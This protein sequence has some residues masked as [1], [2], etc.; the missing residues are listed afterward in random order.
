M[1]SYQCCCLVFAAPHIVYLLS[2]YHRPLCSSSYPTAARPTSSSSSPT[3]SVSPQSG[4]SVEPTNEAGKEAPTR[5][6]AE[7]LR[8][9]TCAALRSRSCC[10]RGDCARGNG[11]TASTRPGDV[12]DRRVLPRPSRANAYAPARSPAALSC[13]IRTAVASAPYLVAREEERSRAD[14]G[15]PRRGELGD[16]WSRSRSERLRRCGLKGEYAPPPRPL[17]HAESPT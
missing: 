7:P 4:A 16:S 5:A 11:G 2:Q 12:T 13:P 6:S 9:C 8:R 10:T 17:W 3:P 1:R 14:K 15:S